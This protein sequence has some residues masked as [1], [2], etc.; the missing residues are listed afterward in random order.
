MESINKM[1]E[2]ANNL[3]YGNDLDAALRCA[4]EIEAEIEAEYMRLPTDM[5]GVP[6]RVGD[7]IVIPNGDKRTVQFI[8]PNCVLPSS[9][10]TYYMAVGC[11]HRALDDVLDDYKHGD[12]TQ[13]GAIAEI[14]ELMGGDA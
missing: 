12:M 3:L 8:A 10:I 6:I 4:G 14:R 13:E 7:K 1:R 11:R 9:P 2:L 5:D